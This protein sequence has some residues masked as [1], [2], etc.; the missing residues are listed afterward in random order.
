MLPAMDYTMNVSVQMSC[1]G[2]AAI[3]QAATSTGP[4]PPLNPNVVVT[5]P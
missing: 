3:R 2:P 5:L 1:L 4:V